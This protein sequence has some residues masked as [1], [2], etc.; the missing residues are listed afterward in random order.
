MGRFWT[1]LGCVLAMLAGAVLLAPW[2]VPAGVFTAGADPGPL[3]RGDGWGTYCGPMSGES[4]FVLGIE[5]LTD[6]GEHHLVLD[7]ASLAAPKNLTE[8][9]AYV[10]LVGPGRGHG[11]FG[12]VPG[13]PPRFFAHGQAAEW[14]ARQ[15]LS[16]TLVPAR[17]S[18]DVVNLLVVVHSPNPDL[19][20]S[21]HHLVVHY[22]SGREQFVYSGNVTYELAPGDHCRT[23]QRFRN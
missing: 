19:M 10:T 11:L 22:H 12:V 1:G 21:V 5:G 18:S 9:G 14:A 20:S 4:D 15:P 2:R 7:S 8:S 17:T 6:T 16:G 23:P 13:I 3:E